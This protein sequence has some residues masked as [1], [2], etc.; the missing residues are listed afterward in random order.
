MKPRESG[1]AKARF[2]LRKA[3]HGSLCLSK[4]A[5]LQ[6][7]VGFLEAKL[8]GLYKLCEAK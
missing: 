1:F 3:E 7:E 6:K 5:D 2:D 4:P 8:G